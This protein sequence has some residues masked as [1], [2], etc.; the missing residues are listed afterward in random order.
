MQ[1][2]CIKLHVSSR[3]T[4]TISLRFDWH[5]KLQKNREN[6]ETQC[7]CMCVS[8]VMGC[9]GVCV[10][11]VHRGPSQLHGS[12][13]RVRDAGRNL[14]S[15]DYCLRAHDTNMTE[16]QLPSN[17]LPLYPLATDVSIADACVTRKGGCRVQ[18]GDSFFWSKL[19]AINF[20]FG[21]ARTGGIINCQLNGLPS[22]LRAPYRRS[23]YLQS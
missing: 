4:P 10:D 1:I 7:V 20:I 21:M 12:R 23:Y 3:Q 15:H 9:V 11:C 22:V 16:W 5:V 18:G 13:N 19:A 6:V 8:A 14:F 2:F 17:P